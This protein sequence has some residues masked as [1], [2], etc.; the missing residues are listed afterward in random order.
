MSDRVDGKLTKLVMHVLL[1]LLML[2]VI[3]ALNQEITES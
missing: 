1:M 3:L 2:K